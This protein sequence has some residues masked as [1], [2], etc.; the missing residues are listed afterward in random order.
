MSYTHCHSPPSLSSN[1]P[2]LLLVIYKSTAQDC[3]EQRVLNIIHEN[4]DKE[5]PSLPEDGLKSLFSSFLNELSANI[6]SFNSPV[7]N[8]CVHTFSSAMNYS[9]YDLIHT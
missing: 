2:K 8:N 4:L 3:L 7:V 9:M 6:D 5:T 1:L